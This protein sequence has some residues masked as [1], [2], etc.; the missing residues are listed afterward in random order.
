MNTERKTQKRTIESRKKLLQAAYELFSDKGYYCT[1]TKEIVK[2]AG[3]SIGNFYNYFQDKGDIYCILFEQ[4]ADES[5]EAMKELTYLLGTLQS[6][7]D[8]KTLLSSHLHQ[9][10]NRTLGTN[11]F[12]EDAV[13]IARENEKLHSIKTVSE[14]KMISVIETFLKKNNPNCQ[15]NYSL[16]ARMLYIITN[17]IA[18][19]IL[20]IHDISQKEDYILLLTEEILHF[21]F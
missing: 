13:V 8:A 6:H 9:L 4:Y 2:R 7:S 1:N 17:E 11:K 14:E 18:N 21:I 5:Y 3:I 15:E 12:L 16:K 19:D 20:C 10:L